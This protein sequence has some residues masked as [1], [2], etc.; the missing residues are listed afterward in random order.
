MIKVKMPLHFDDIEK[1]IKENICPACIYGEENKITYY[2]WFDIENHNSL[3]TMIT[4]SKNGFCRKHGWEISMLG[5][6]LS[7]LNQ[8]VIMEKLAEL[9]KMKAFIRSSGKH[10]GPFHGLTLKLKRN[11]LKRNLQQKILN[12]KCPVC[13]IIEEGETM[14]LILLN[15]FLNKKGGLETYQ[16]NPSLCWRHLCGL[17]SDATFETAISLIDI[18]I[19]QLQKID[20]DFNEYFRK[21]DYRFSKEPK[22]E[23]QLAWLKSLKFY[24][25]EN[26]E[27]YR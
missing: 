25:G 9:E 7:V 18:H 8:F 5:N 11:E 22:G 26:L 27:D 19:N 6:K 14:A 16:K 17:I 2:K 15:N 23:E 4:I 1:L 13:K 21:T 10:T 3:P 12:Q 24:V 20:S